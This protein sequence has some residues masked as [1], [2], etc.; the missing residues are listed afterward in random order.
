M[1]TLSAEALASIQPDAYAALVSYAAEHGRK[2][3]ADL[4][5]DWY[6][7]RAIGDRGALLHALRNHPGFGFDGLDN[8]RLPK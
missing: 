7:A 2:W 5:L 8:F 6:N 3:K 1:K 4:S